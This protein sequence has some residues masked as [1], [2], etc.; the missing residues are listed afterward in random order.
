LQNGKALMKNEN[1]VLS[2]K[3]IDFVMSLY[4]QGKFEEAVVQIKALNETYPNV[5]LLFNLIGACYR[6]LGQL[7]GSIQMFKSAVK[8]KPNYAEAFFNLGFAFKENGK[9]DESI[10]CYRKAILI[11][12]NYPDAYNNLGNI[13]KDD[14][15]NLI[16]AIENLEWAV[17][18]SPN[19]AE[20]HNNLGLALSDFGRAKE[21]IKSFEK[22]VKINPE[23]E[24][25]FFNLAM[26]FKDL[27]N[28]EEFIK[29]IEK[30]I[31]LRPNW[32]DAHLHLSRAKKY[33]KNDPKI[34]EME[35]YLSDSA[36]DVIDRIALNFA[37]AHI[38]ESHG[39]HN[40]QFKY[41]NEANRLRKIELNYVIDKDEKLFDRI[42]EVFKSE[43][44]C[45]EKDDIELSK[46]RPI[47]IVGMPRSGTS[48]VHQIIGSHNKVYGAGELNQLNQFVV[49]FLKQY[50]SDKRLI[51]EDLLAIRNQY[52]QYI[53]S[54]NVNH[55]I[56]IDKMPLNFRHIGFMVSAFPEA[57]IIHMNRDPMATCW[58]IYKYYFNGNS[59]SYDQ[60]DLA[61][62]Y[63]LYRELMAFWRQLFPN[64][65]YDLS[66]ENLTTNQEELTRKLL[67]YCELEWDENCLNFHKND[68]AVRTTSAL[69]V[70]QKIYQGSSDV[71]KKYEDYLQPLI[72]GLNYYN[73]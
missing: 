24:S 44:V 50:D 37:L 20:A 13:L 6:E 27:G 5:P 59:Y 48:L 61:N 21:A 58:S 46:I 18:Y 19:F 65:I 9:I 28:K 49:P 10:E 73:D 36:L 30:A 31:K 64:K 39:S 42:R 52:L 43:F 7:E 66:Y 40:E 34:S 8:I 54:L 56:I 55:K 15:K 1:P 70:K 47:F 69:Q 71:W 53:G 45:L 25:A 3:Q 12:P 14:K 62:Y 17:A 72:N 2:R 32:G 38:Y 51:K 41:L 35:S 29:Y 33:N 26:V 16:E 63:H 4:T 11:Q 57:K 23:Y 22:A 68:T 60:Q 67:K